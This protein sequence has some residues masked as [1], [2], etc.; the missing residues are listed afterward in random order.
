VGDDHSTVTLV[1]KSLNNLPRSLV[2]K[3]ER[4][5]DDGLSLIVSIDMSLP[6][7]DDDGVNLSAMIGDVFPEPIVE[8]PAFVSRRQLS[9]TCGPHRQAF[10]V[11]TSRD[12]SRTRVRQKIRHDQ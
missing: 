2:R 1:A 11:C 3:G 9:W 6:F 8:C 7:P 5:L 4:A 12:E 10:R